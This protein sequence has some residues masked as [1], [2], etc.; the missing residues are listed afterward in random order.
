M[1]GARSNRRRNFFALHPKC[2]FCGG[3]ADATT[4]DH[5]PGR[6]LFLGRQWPSGYVFPACFSCN[7]EAS[8]GEALLA[9]LVR[10]RITDFSPEEEREFNRCTYEVSRRFPE[11]VDG[12]KFHSRVESRRFLKEMGVP[13]TMPGVDGVLHSMDFPDHVLDVASD[14]G[15]KLGKALHYFHSG[16]IVPSVAVID[17]KVYTNANAMG[18]QFPA[19]ALAFITGQAEIQRAS[20]SLISQFDYR[21][22]VVEGGEASAF[23]ISFGESLV[24]VVSIFADPERHKQAQAARKLRESQVGTALFSAPQSEH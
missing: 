22:T 19:Q 18:P 2:C 15:V 4:E 1:A 16:R 12:L 3:S 9:W 20:T 23:V 5:V 17:A 8:Q 7:N 24:I 21:Y 11:I 13:T 14:Y 10:I 6:G